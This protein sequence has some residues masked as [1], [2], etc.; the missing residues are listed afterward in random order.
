V[1]PASFYPEG[2]VPNYIDPKKIDRTSGFYHGSASAT[3]GPLTE[4]GPQK[5]NL[6]T[7]DAFFT[8]D[9]KLAKTYTGGGTEGKAATE[10]WDKV[11]KAQGL[12]DKKLLDLYPQG[13]TLA[14]QD[15]K[16]FKQI[17]RDIE[18]GAYPESSFDIGDPNNANWTKEYNPDGLFVGDRYKGKM[19]Y[20]Q[21]QASQ[22]INQIKAT[23]GGFGRA[24]HKGATNPEGTYQFPAPI[25]RFGNLNEINARVG[26]V[27]ANT[28]LKRGWDGFTHE[29]GRATGG[30]SHQ[31]AALWNAK[32]TGLAK[33]PDADTTLPAITPIRK[34][35]APGSWKP[36]RVS[37]QWSKLISPKVASLPDL[38]L[39]G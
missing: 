18:E 13:K 37:Q 15:P 2:A 25:D 20:S 24:R 36:N 38:G 27:V 23:E 19:P 17:L 16:L 10:T 35:E 8:D 14:S 7:G 26:N 4:R 28:A 6:L 3:L 29:G 1:F 12:Q 21:K 31:V 11:Y 33:V 32:G 9:P 5:Q 34:I 22:W 39:H 30:E